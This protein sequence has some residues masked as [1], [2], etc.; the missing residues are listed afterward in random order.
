MKI[1]APVSFIVFAAAAYMAG[2][3]KL[4]LWLMLSIIVVAG[5]LA[6]GVRKSLRL[7]VHPLNE[8]P[9]TL[10]LFAA[11][12]GGT[13]TGIGAREPS[14]CSIA[15]GL[16]LLALALLLNDEDMRYWYRRMLPGRGFMLVLL[17]IDGSGKTTHM[18]R[19]LELY[20]KLGLRVVEHHYHVYLFVD[21]LSRASAPGRTGKPLDVRRYYFHSGGSV[22]RILRIVR[23]LLSLLDNILLYLF[24]IKPKL[25]RGSVVVSHRFIWST[26]IKYKALGYPVKGLEKLWFLLRPHYAIIFDIPGIVSYERVLRRG[27]HIRYPPWVL[28]EERID[29]L[30]IARRYGYPVVDTSSRSVEES[31]REARRYALLAALKY[32]GLRVQ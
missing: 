15:V 27:E 12:F 31:W 14:P 29:Y 3:E 24:V 5:Y 32:G 1:I 6:W 25:M 18:R 21:K 17:G 20:R 22:R 9:N 30:R 26:Y 28:E 7:G 13:L 10:R 4:S 8:A 23:A 2:I 16:A 19:I 11:V